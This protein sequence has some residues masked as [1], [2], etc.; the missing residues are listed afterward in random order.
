MLLGY[1]LTQCHVDV[2]LGPI[3]TCDF[4]QVFVLLQ[5]FYDKFSNWF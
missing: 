2:I 3:Y 5:L 4:L 1:I